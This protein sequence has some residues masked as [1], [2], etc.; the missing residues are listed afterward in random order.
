MERELDLDDALVLVYGMTRDAGRRMGAPLYPE[1]ICWYSDNPTAV[2]PDFAHVLDLL[3]E[4]GAVIERAGRY[5]VTD[6]PAGT[7]WE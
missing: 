3:V 4:R 2:V 1:E 6:D 5:R 7:E